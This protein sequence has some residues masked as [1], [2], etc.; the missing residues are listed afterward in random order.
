MDATTYEGGLG[1]TSDGL[2]YLQCVLKLVA[3][4]GKANKIRGEC[5]DI[6]DD[7]FKVERITKAT[8]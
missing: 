5:F 6:A 7:S 2:C 3:Y 1:V 8:P 4:R